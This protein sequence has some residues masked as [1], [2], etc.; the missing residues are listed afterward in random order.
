MALFSRGIRWW[1][2]LVIWLMLPTIGVLAASLPGQVFQKHSGNVLSSGLFAAEGILFATGRAMPAGSSSEA[3]LAAERRA[4]SAAENRLLDWA[5]NEVRW[6]KDISPTATA[7]LWS[8]FRRAEIRRV[9]LQGLQRI[10]CRKQADGSYT[11]VVALPNY[12]V[13]IPAN[14]YQEISQALLRALKRRDSNVDV[15]AVMEI[16]PSSDMEGAVSLLAERAERDVGP[17]A[18]CTLRGMALG[19]IIALKD[20]DPCVDPLGPDGGLGYLWAQLEARPY[21]PAVCYRLGEVL[22]HSGFRQAASVLFR[23]GAGVWP[24]APASR[25]CRSANQIKAAAP[26]SRL[27]PRDFWLEITEAVPPCSQL[28]GHAGRLVVLSMGDLPLEVD[29]A[30]NDTLKGGLSLFYKNPPDLQGSLTN[31]LA[32][33]DYNLTADGCNLAGRCLMLTRRQILAAPFFAQALRFAPNHPHAVGN[34]REAVE[35]LQN[36]RGRGSTRTN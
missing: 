31:A 4:E 36:H 25:L 7:R 13:Q 8:S 24:N 16:C 15:V 34:L 14:S 22:Q 10:E 1:N 20:V 30:E 2:T 3:Q 27:I 12:S 32:S 26:V 19:S 28:L 23:R 35:W 18:A 11:A 21:Q 5:T 6:P 9:E 29:R 33:L 17:N